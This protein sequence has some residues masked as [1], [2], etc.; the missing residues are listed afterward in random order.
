M[1]ITININD[2]LYQRVLTLT[3]DKQNNSKLF[4]EILE[5]Y[6]RIETAKRLAALGGKGLNMKNIHRRRAIN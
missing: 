6:V 2:D 5:T 3:A 1:R 4:T